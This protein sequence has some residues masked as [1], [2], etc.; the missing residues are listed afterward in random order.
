MKIYFSKTE[1]II[2]ELR[3]FF[4]SSSPDPNR[5][6]MQTQIGFVLLQGS[7]IRRGEI[8]KIV[9]LIGRECIM[10]HMLNNS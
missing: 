7:V 4:L 1:E 6:Y 10:G 3:I 9:S 2:Q 8:M 5:G